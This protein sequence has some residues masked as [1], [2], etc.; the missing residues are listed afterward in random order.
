M[1]HL[2]L[3]LQGNLSSLLIIRAYIPAM[4]PVYDTLYG[5]SREKSIHTDTMCTCSMYG[6]II[7]H[8][9]GLSLSS[10]HS[11]IIR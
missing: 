10:L 11:F 9:Q 3:F 8:L 6:A 4:L 1:H 2:Q 5:V 7:Y